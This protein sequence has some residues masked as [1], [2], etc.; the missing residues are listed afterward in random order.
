M[1]KELDNSTDCVHQFLRVQTLIK[2]K[3][4]LFYCLH[5]KETFVNILVY[6]YFSSFNF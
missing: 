3:F 6:G 2:Q 5:F 1:L 4:F